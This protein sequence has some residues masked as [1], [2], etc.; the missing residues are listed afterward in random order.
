MSEQSRR[1]ILKS[2]AAGGGAFIAGK[3]LPSTWIKPVVD[4]VVLPA[5]AQTSTCTIDITWIITV[6]GGTVNYSEDSTYGYEIT[7]YPGGGNAVAPLNVHYS[8]SVNRTESISLPPGQYLVGAGAGAMV[9]DPVTATGHTTISCCTA[10]MPL[11]GTWTANN[12]NTDTGDGDTVLVTIG[13]D[14]TC[15]ITP[16]SPM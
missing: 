8:S 9:S 3:S 10:S 2:I 7:Y 14:G 13:A 5:H 12:S 4:S 1:K 6:T 11:G 16:G 15:K